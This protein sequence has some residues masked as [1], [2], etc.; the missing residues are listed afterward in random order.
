MI[1]INVRLGVRLLYKET[2]RF[3]DFFLHVEVASKRIGDTLTYNVYRLIVEA[4]FVIKI[5]R[6]C[7]N[8]HGME[9]S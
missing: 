7:G 3:S 9:H 8:R 2:Y 4:I 1:S 5:Y 6:T